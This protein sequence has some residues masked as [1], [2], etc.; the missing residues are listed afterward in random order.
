VVWGSMEQIEAQLQ[1]TKTG[2]KINTSYI[3]R[4]NATFRACLAGLVTAYAS[5][6]PS[7]W[8]R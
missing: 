2:T 4:L 3:E 8:R 7:K 1:Q 5:F 6:S